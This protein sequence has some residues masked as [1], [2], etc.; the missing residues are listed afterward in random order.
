V[1]WHCGF[2]NRSSV[3]TAP[4][5]SRLSHPLPLGVNTPFF[6]RLPG[7]GSNGS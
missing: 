5:L 4:T 3:P 2:F 6:V 1:I 7:V